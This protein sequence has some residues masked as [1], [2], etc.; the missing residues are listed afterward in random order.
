MEWSIDTL[1]TPGYEPFLRFSVLK[2][3][4]VGK[5]TFFVWLYDERLLYGHGAFCLL[6]L[7]MFTPVQRNGVPSVPV[8]LGVSNF[9]GVSRLHGFL[10]LATNVI[11]IF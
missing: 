6:F 4:G 9:S 10:I 8:F 2:Q 3:D 7:P 5:I 11:I 1:V